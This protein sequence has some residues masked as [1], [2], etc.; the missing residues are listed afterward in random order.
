[1]LTKQE[2][3]EIVQYC[4]ENGKSFK[5]RLIELNI[6]AWK[7]YDARKK[8]CYRDSSKGHF[9][10]LQPSNADEISEF[11]GASAPKTRTSHRSSRKENEVALVHIEMKT[12]TGSLLRIQG[13][14]T[15]KVLQDIILASSGYVQ[16]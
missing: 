5:E 2:M 12:A 7:F 14:F 4:Q 3:E 16:P 1:M 9:L 13:E 10:Q 15:S 6:P 8:Y 11:F